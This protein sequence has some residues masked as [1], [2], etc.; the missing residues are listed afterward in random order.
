MPQKNIVRGQSVS[1]EKVV[2]AKEFLRNTTNAEK[3]L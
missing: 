3:I 1:A 2:K